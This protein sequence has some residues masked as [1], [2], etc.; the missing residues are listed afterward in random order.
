MA[1]TVLPVGSHWP[2][3]LKDYDYVRTLSK[4]DRGWEYLRR[5]PAYCDDF[6]NHRTLLPPMERWDANVV[7]YRLRQSMPR[8]AA[9]GLSSFRRS[10][11]RRTKCRYILVCY[12][13]FSGP[14]RSA[15][16]C[17]SRLRR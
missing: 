1:Q 7:V 8:A 16:S 14:D 11:P 9:W 6:L 2:P 4:S 3:D 17:E 5:S 12:R 15:D 10:E 13:R